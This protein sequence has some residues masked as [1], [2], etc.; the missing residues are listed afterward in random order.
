MK[1][2]LKKGHHKSNHHFLLITK[3]AIFLKCFKCGIIQ[4]FS[5]DRSKKTISILFDNFKNEILEIVHKIDEGVVD[6]LSCNDKF[7]TAITDKC[8]IKGNH[9]GVHRIGLHHHTITTNDGN[10]LY[11][12]NVIQ[13][14]F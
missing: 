14:S 6:L 4:N 13:K 1:C 9:D 7:I 11:S 8:K 5:D 10:T 2:P 3:Q 12:F